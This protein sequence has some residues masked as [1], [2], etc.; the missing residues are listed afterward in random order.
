MCLLCPCK[1]CMC[2]EHLRDGWREHRAAEEDIRV[3]W[4][5]GRIW[6]PTL[7]SDD[8]KKLKKHLSAGRREGQRVRCRRLAKN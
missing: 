6:D 2:N 7:K 8:G 4:A 1:M 5:E 3:G